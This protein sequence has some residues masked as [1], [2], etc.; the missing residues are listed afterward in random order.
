MHTGNKIELAEF[1]LM[2]V[3]EKINLIV[4]H[5]IYNFENS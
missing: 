3:N 4:F 1:S 5:L 2:S